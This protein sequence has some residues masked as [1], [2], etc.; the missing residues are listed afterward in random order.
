VLVGGA[1]GQFGGVEATDGH[2]R[3]ECGLVVLIDVDKDRVLNRE[4]LTGRVDAA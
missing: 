1:R 4:V 3:Y 2:L